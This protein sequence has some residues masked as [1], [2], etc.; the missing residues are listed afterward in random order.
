MVLNHRLEGLKI[1]AAV[2]G[3]G[4]D[5]AVA[6]VPQADGARLKALLV[7]P[8]KLSLRLVDASV[9]VTDAK[10]GKTPPESDAL[11]GADGT[12]YLIEKRIG[13]RATT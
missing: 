4:G 6:V 12:P 1:K 3:E 9:S 10:S 7:A 13:W 8:G 11:S 2:R 5:T